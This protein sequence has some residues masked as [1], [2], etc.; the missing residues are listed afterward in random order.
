M[1]QLETKPGGRK[2]VAAAPKGDALPFT[3]KNYYIFAAGLVAIILGYVLL[4]QGDISLAP[5]L[6]VVGY[7]VIIPIAILY[8][9]KDEKPVA[10]GKPGA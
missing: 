6:L 10:E 7:C 8:R 1:A 2:P 4:G 9:A 5:I 3:K